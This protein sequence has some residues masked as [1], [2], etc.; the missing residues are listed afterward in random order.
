MAEKIV[1]E[2]RFHRGFFWP[3]IIWS[4]PF[5]IIYSCFA[6]HFFGKLLAADSKCNSCKLCVSKCPAKAMEY[7]DGQIR[8]K[9]SC[10]GCMRCINSCP[11]NAIQTSA[12]RLLAAFAAVI[13]NPYSQISKIIPDTF[14]NS[15][16]KYGSAIFNTLMSLL[17]FIVSLM[18]LDKIINLI[19]KSV[20][21][22][23][24]V[25]WGHTRYY[26]RYTADQ[27]KSCLKNKKTDSIEH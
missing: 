6:R 16:G 19:S 11:K 24:I 8:W 7:K 25:G 18:L 20:V 14:Y 15:I 13:L 26:N 3:N 21:I 1:K 10:E 27:F 2:R 9:L 23:K 17:V 22:K 4:V 5:G 12:V